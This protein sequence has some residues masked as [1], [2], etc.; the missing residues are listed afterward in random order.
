MKHWKETLTG[1]NEVYL[2]WVPSHSDIHGNE[3]AGTGLKDLI[4][5]SVIGNY[6]GLVKS[7]INEET[8]KNHQ[9]EWECFKSCR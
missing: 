8:S 6:A 1:N 9:R 2:M 5:K 4:P 3:K 7:L